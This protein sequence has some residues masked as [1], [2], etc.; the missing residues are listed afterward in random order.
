MPKI[1]V[2]MP[3]YIADYLADT[4][5]LTGPQH[6]SYLLLIAHEWRTGRL[7]NDMKL[8]VRLTRNEF[9]LS[10]TPSIARVVLENDSSTAKNEHETTQEIVYRWLRCLLEEFFTLDGEGHWF[11]GRMEEIQE[12][13][14]QKKVR[15]VEKSKKAIKTRW[16]RIRALRAAAGDT[17]SMKSGD[18]PSIAEVILEPF[19][20]SSSGKN[21]SKVPTHSSNAG[22]DLHQNAA[23][24]SPGPRKSRSQPPAKNRRNPE[25]SQNR[26]GGAAKPRGK[27]KGHSRPVDAATV[28]KKLIADGE[29]SARRPPKTRKDVDPRFGP[30]REQIFLYWSGIHKTEIEAGLVPR[31]PPWGPRERV[32][33]N[34]LLA[35]SPHLSLEQFK[36]MLMLRASSKVN[37]SFPPYRWMKELFGFAASAQDRYSQPLT[38]KSR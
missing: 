27:G 32:E 18:T 33:L 4:S 5:H 29:N 31:D 11:N 36:R 14:L 20:S 23:L 19:P 2:W 28:P 34:L 8:I 16:D 37:H 15:R 35:S 25:P 10:L 24:G 13:W 17:P 12:E 1:D 7:P 6:G 3:W 9:F 22:F 38:P 30:F 26:P 21:K